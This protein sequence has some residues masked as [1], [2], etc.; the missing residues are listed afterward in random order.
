MS[1]RVLAKVS[2]LAADSY[3]KPLPI[4]KTNKVKPK[5]ESWKKL[6]QQRAVN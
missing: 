4:K 5:S 2:E 1:T 3:P 6:G